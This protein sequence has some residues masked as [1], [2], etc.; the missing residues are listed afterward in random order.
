MAGYP[1]PAPTV[2][3]RSMKEIMGHPGPY[4][5]QSAALR[6][7]IVIDGYYQR[8]DPSPRPALQ[9][10][11]AY[12]D[13]MVR[14]QDGSWL[15]WAGLAERDVHTAMEHGAKSWTTGK[16]RPRA[17]QL[18]G[19]LAE[20]QRAYGHDNILRFGVTGLLVRCHDKV[21]RMENLTG[22]YN[23]EWEPLDDTFKDLMGYAIIGIMLDFGTFTL[24]LGGELGEASV[25]HAHQPSDPTPE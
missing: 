17:K 2:D 4:T 9:N 24:P 25:Q 18:I 7:A 11:R 20:K 19:F 10:L 3:R 6:A 22:Q 13:Y 23:P 12:L 5:W 21:A 14:Q 8:A 1:P 16:G 15:A